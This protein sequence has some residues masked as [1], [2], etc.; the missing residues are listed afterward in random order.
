MS[1]S[2]GKQFEKKLQEDFIK[3]VPNSTIDR[4][5]DS[6]SGFKSISNICDFIAYSKPNIF[7]LEAKSH[8]GNTFPLTNLT[9][10]EKLSGKLGIP[11]VRVGVIIWFIDHKRVLYVPINTVSKL[12]SDNKKSININKIF[13]EGYRVFEIP[14]KPK[15]VFLDSD[16]SILT[17][18]EDND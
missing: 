16:Y 6:V 11:G 13:N 12:I 3:S 8:K 7:Y 15:R 4:I 18:L 14:S 9:Q 1:V 17:N 2:K 10:Y 5:Y